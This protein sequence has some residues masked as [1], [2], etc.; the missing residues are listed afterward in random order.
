MSN[1]MNQPII[2][3]EVSGGLVQGVY[4]ENVPAGFK[5]VVVD[6]DFDNPANEDLPA[7]TLLNPERLPSLA[8]IRVP[9]SMALDSER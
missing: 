1:P 4:F 8:K 9:V 7:A 5:V 6:H 2:V 3:V